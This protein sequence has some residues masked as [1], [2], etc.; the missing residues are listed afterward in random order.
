MFDCRA[1]CLYGRGTMRNAVNSC[2]R[3]TATMRRDLF[4][5]AAARFVQHRR[6][7]AQGAQFFVTPDATALYC[8]SHTTH[9][10]VLISLESAIFWPYVLAGP[11]AWA[12]YGLGMR[13][14]RRRMSLLDREAYEVAKP[15][16]RVTILVPAKDED[17]SI[18]ACL[19]SALAQDYP[20]FELLAIDDRSTDRT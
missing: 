11:F 4:I 2:P 3:D 7:A 14:G 15:E 5:D 9:R 19:E 18:R 10:T 13:A 16:P 8:P 6:A 12:L 1:S 20:N 17:A